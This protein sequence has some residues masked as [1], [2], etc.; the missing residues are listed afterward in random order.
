MNP[1]IRA[2][3]LVGGPTQASFLC[4]VSAAAIF[5]WRKLGRVYD[6]RAAVLLARASGVPIEQLA[7]VDVGDGTAGP[8]PKRRKGRRGGRIPATYPVASSYRNDRSNRNRMP[9]ARHAAA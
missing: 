7:G 9:A 3:R 8:A 5:K 4:R 6:A 2:V 1:V